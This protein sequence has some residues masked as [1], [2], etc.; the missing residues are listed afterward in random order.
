MRVKI[1]GLAL[2]FSVA[3]CAKWMD[4]YVLFPDPE[5]PA[6][7]G[8]AHVEVDRASITGIDLDFRLLIGATDGGVLL[9][10][11]LVPNYSVEIKDAH[12]CDGGQ[13]GNYVV[14]DYFPKSPSTSSMVD[15]RPG[16][17]FGKD[18]HFPLF[19]ERE[20]GGGVPDC[21]DA[22]F[23]LHLANALNPHIPFQVR[24]YRFVSEGD[25]GQ[26]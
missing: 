10:R 16:E 20:D 23:T 25:A 19:L 14:V 4:G 26:P 3:G 7:V 9:D 2:M 1:A 13:R 6:S 15:L 8:I 22:T 18:V 5:R 11:R 17:W 24:G 12:D 21:V